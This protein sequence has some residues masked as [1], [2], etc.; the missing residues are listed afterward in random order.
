MFKKRREDLETLICGDDSP[1]RAVFGNVA[2]SLLLESRGR[3][4]IL[5]TSSIAGE[6]KTTVAVNIA[7]SL[8]RAG[9]KVLLI[10]ANPLSPLLTDILGLT[11]RPGLAELAEGKAS[12]S[13]AADEIASLSLDAIGA[14]LD[15]DAKPAR[16]FSSEALKET[17]SEAKSIYDRVILDAPAV[18]VARSF[19]HLSDEVDKIIYV[20]A[21]GVVKKG[22]LT[23]ARAEMEKAWD[24]DVSVLLNRHYVPRPHF[25]S[26][27]VWE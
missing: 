9:A 17:L 22:Q 18:G 10:D 14:G 21:P 16:L 23:R 20:V 8:A 6:G 25:L 5:I 13:E 4:A 2:S 19:L 26:K 1:A 12:L 27:W 7:A 15:T 11:E 24:K 3:E